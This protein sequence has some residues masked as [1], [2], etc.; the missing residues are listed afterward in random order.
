MLVSQTGMFYLFFIQFQ[1]AGSHTESISGVGLRWE[2]VN[3][4]DVRNIVAGPHIE[5]G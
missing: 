1:F 4:L 2:K 3:N 5:Q